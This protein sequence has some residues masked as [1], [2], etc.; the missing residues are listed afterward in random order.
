[1]SYYTRLIGIFLV[2]VVVAA[3]IFSFVVRSSSQAGETE[4]VVYVNTPKAKLI[5]IQ[6]KKDGLVSLDLSGNN[7]SFIDDSNS[8]FSVDELRRGFVVRASG[9]WTDKKTLRV[10]NLH[11]VTVPNISVF[12]PTEGETVGIPLVGSGEARVFENAY[13]YRLRDSDGSILG[14]GFDTANA[15]DVGK[16]GPFSFSLFY[17][18]PKGATGMLEVFTSS[19]KDGSEIDMVRVPV[20]FEKGLSEENDM[21]SISL[22]FTN[23]EKDPGAKECEKT[24]PV[25]RRISKTPTPA[26]SAIDLLLAGPTSAEKNRWIRNFY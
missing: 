19:A 5:T 21:V 9:A 23:S 3:G 16:F 1:M 15:P 11:L 6:T 4:G 26:R 14:E 24:Y 17:P 2:G 13:Q 20:V 7:F 12:T 10:S 22:F 8:R 25:T 18:A